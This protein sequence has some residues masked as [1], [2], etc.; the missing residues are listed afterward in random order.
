MGE[1][2]KKGA[3]VSLP[4]D[5]TPVVRLDSTQEHEADELHRFSCA[6]RLIT[7]HK[8]IRSGLVYGILKSAWSPKG[9]LELHEQSKHTYVF[10]LSDEKEKQR[11]FSS[12]PWSVKGFHLILKDWPRSQRFDEIDFSRME[13]W[14]QVHGLPKDA[15]TVENAKRIGSLFPRLISWDESTL[16]GQESF[17]RLRVEIDL[18]VPLL[19]GFQIAGSEA[20]LKLAKFKYEKLADF[21]YQCGMLDHTMKTCADYHWTDEDGTYTSQARPAYGPSLRAPIYSPRRHFGALRRSPQPFKP[22]HTINPSSTT[23]LMDTQYTEHPEANTAGE[24]CVDPICSQQEHVP[25]C[26]DDRVTL[27]SPPPLSSSFNET[28]LP[29]SEDN[30]GCPQSS[31]RPSDNLSLTVA[32]LNANVTTDKP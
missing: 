27:F 14:V 31:S 26:E 16:G 32:S 19:T 21:C 15:M 22:T 23:P 29:S 28:G 10:I 17:L 2:S 18:H 12:S 8:D 11:I 20:E 3:T 6:G 24:L 9:G 13:F 4:L 7:T 30:N 25:H 5:H 1:H